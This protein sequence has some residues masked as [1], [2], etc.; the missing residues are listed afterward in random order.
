MYIDK[1]AKIFIVV[2]FII[3]A[4]TYVT[5]F[6]FI[7]LLKK[8]DIVEIFDAY[9]SS[10][11][12]NFSVEQNCSEKSHIIFRVWD[13]KEEEFR[14]KGDHG[15]TIVTKEIVGKTNLDKINGHYFCFKNI[16]YKDLLYNDQ[17]IKKEEK[18]GNNYPK[19]CGTIDTLNQHLCIKNDESCP[20]YDVGIGE[21]KNL[22]DYNYHADAKIYY[23]N[24][25][26]DNQNKKIIGKLILNDGQPCYNINEKLWRKF[27]DKEGF[28][29]HLECD[30]DIFGNYIDDKYKWKGSITYLQLYKDNLSEDSFNLVCNNIKGDQYVS[31][32][33]REFLGIDKECDKNYKINRSYNEKLKKIPKMEKI[34]LIVEVVILILVFVSFGIILYRFEDITCLEGYRDFNKVILMCIIF[35]FVFVICQSVFLGMIVYYDLSYNCSDDKTNELLRKENRKTKNNIIFIAINLGLDAFN[36]FINLIYLLINNVLFKYCHYFEKYDEENKRIKSE[37]E[38]ERERENER[39]RERERNAQHA[40][41]IVVNRRINNGTE[42]P[43]REYDANRGNNNN[44]QQNNQPRQIRYNNN[45]SLHT[46]DMENTIPT[47]N[48]NFE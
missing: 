30:L 47:S 15:T 21:N 32:Y 17:I 40:R 48:E 16:S 23:N 1:F 8:A 24:N 6:V 37:R 29:E 5:H 45:I 7:F 46:S 11:L 31:L 19:D 39:E 44:E 33:A 12:F 18:C 41:E 13:G 26:Y 2:D 3:F 28:E 42:E 22:P 20:L 14:E 36:V 25:N 9:E 10:P 35:I 43:I 27:N 4:I 34:S 38:R